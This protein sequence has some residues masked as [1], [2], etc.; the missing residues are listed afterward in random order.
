[1]LIPFQP[2]FSPFT[3]FSSSPPL[4]LSH[5][6]THTHFLS[7]FLHLTLFLCSECKSLFLKRTS[8]LES[9]RTNFQKLLMV[10]FL[11]MKKQVDTDPQIKPILDLF[12]LGGGGG[13]GRERKNLNSHVTKNFLRL[14]IFNKCYPQNPKTPFEWKK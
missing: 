8:N 2:L 4:S 13:G 12:F 11:T 3:S 14:W 5:S 7:F 10:L 1:M 9:E 6:L